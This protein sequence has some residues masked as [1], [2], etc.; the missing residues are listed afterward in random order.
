MPIQRLLLQGFCRCREVANFL[1][2]YIFLHT[3]YFPVF[4]EKYNLALCVLPPHSLGFRCGDI[5]VFWPHVHPLSIY[6]AI[7][8]LSFYSVWTFTF[9]SLF[10]NRKQEHNSRATTQHN[11]KTLFTIS[12]FAYKITKN[13][14]IYMRKHYLYQITLTHLH[15]LLEKQTC[16]LL[17]VFILSMAKANW[18]LYSPTCSGI[19]LSLNFKY[20]TLVRNYK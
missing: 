4:A 14:V 8:T 5:P 7:P 13:S 1:S 16:S 12:T 10:L 15:I 6:A 17:S 11:S 2:F 20:W 19:I 9:P 18:I 3:W